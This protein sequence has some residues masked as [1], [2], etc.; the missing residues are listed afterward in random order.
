[1]TQLVPVEGVKSALIYSLEDLSG[2]MRHPFVAAEM[3][4]HLEEAARS[5]RRREGPRT[6]LLIWDAYR[7]RP[8]QHAIYGRYARELSDSEAIPYDEAYAKARSFITP[9]DGD[10]PHGTGGAVD[11]TLLLDGQ[12]ACMGTDFDA[13]VDR[14]AADWYREHPPVAAEDREAA[15]NREIL[16]AAMEDAGFVVLDKEWWHFEWGT[17]RWAAHTGEPALLRDMLDEPRVSDT[18]TSAFTLPLRQPVGY[19]SVTQVFSDPAKRAAALMN[20]APGHLYSRFSNPTVAALNDYMRTVCC[21]ARYATATSSG[22]AACLAAFQA[23]VP[24]G[25][26]VVYDRYCYY[27]IERSLIAMADV[28]GWHLAEADFTDLRAVEETCAELA[29]RGHGVDLLFCDSPRNWWLESLDIE[30]LARIGGSVGALLAVDSSVQPLQDLLGRGADAVIVSLSKY[31]SLGMALGGM[32]LTDREMVH[33][34]V[35]RAAVDRTVMLSGDNAMAI[36]AQAV[37]LRD[38]MASVSAKTERIAAHLTGLTSV[39]AVRIADGARSGGFTGGQIVVHTASSDVAH[40]AERLVGHN[41]LRSRSGLHL[42]CTYGSC[43]TTF[44]HFASNARHL[45]GL[46]PRAFAEA[47][48][49]DDMV[50]VGVGCE[51]VDDIIADLD[52]VLNCAYELVQ[53]RLKN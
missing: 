38:R 24:P 14:A 44:E 19:M 51:D 11:V 46:P 18:A 5:L 39:R 13:F 21:P 34:A 32:V 48:L 20:A 37:S 3:L 26:T 52:L 28:F 45:S 41:A 17:D 2:A 30:G 9:P 1:M 12:P 25:G 33:T 10:H 43:M 15:E 49:P 27:E 4:P 47:L 16:R 53:G 31:P 7:T 22:S 6:E 23:L 29:R 50:R 35:H 36:W 8:T 40:V 42:A